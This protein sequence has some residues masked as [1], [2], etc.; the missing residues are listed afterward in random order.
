MGVE[1]RLR[2]L[3]RHLRDPDEKV[4]AAVAASIERLERL[5]RLDTLTEALSAGET[6]AR[7]EAIYALAELAVPDAGPHL[8]AAAASQEEDVRATAVVALGRVRYR[9]AVPLLIERL[10]DPSPAV[11][12]QAADALGQI[13]APEA[14]E[15]LLVALDDD[16][17]GV[18]AAA[19]DALQKVADASLVPRLS[20]RLAGSGGPESRAAAAAVLGAIGDPAAESV[21]R[22]SLADDN[23]AV[24]ASAAAALGKLSVR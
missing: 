14:Q 1:E 8:M 22:L 24:R 15:A 3:R 2:E 4:R 6:Q 21:L 17:P 9:P 12:L 11:R 18:V 19:G 20:E 7:L 10:Q 23:A 5:R 13:E 16:A